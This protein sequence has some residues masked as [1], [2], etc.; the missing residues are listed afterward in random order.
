M[1]H[2]GQKTKDLRKKADLTQERLVDYLGVSAQAVSKWEVGSASP[3][4]SLIAPLCRVLGCSA[5]KLLG[6]DLTE[7]NEGAEDLS[8]ELMRLS[9][10]DLERFED[11]VA[12][13]AQKYPR[14]EQV[15]YRIA[16]TDYWRLG[17]MEGKTEEERRRKADAEKRLLALLADGKN[18][19]WKTYAA[20]Q[21]FQM[22]MNDGLREEAEAFAEQSGPFRDEN[23]LACLDGEDWQNEQQF[24]VYKSLNWL[25]NYLNMR[26]DRENHLPSYEAAEAVV[27]AIITDGNYVMYARGL[28]ESAVN[29]AR[30]FVEA[31][32]YGRAV[33][34]L[35]DQVEYDE[36]WYRILRA[37]AEDPGRYL[38][39]TA[40]VLDRW[41]EGAGD[42]IDREDAVLPA[43]RNWRKE[44]AEFLKSAPIYAPLR[45]REDFE[46]LIAELGS[47]AVSEKE[48][49][50]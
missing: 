11:I 34:K 4:L 2:I 45:E 24:L 9:R 33:E 39:Y 29:Q 26:G 16:E 6:I 18:E 22:R 23:L 46:A 37:A 47:Q 41:G 28:S 50:V 44:R 38:P 32:E 27:K 19:T 15:S 14:N 17:G 10:E 20:S 1:E 48:E 7:D 3:D 35:R 5:D 25:C 36:Q 43:G 30:L 40:P 13:A 49:T 21:L 42:L 31:G 12:L 8:K